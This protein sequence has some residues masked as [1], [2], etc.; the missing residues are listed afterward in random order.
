MQ[1]PTISISV[2]HV[3]N[4]AQYKICMKYKLNLEEIEMSEPALVELIF[5]GILILIPVPE[6]EWPQIN[7]KYY[8]LSSGGTIKHTNWVNGSSDK[9]R[10]STMN[11]FKSSLEASINRDS[12]V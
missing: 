9:Y 7:K 1:N 3:A 12:L 4:A 6:K 5:H 11:V 2:R 10:K 8:Y